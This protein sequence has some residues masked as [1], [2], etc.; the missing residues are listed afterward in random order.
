MTSRA[1]LLA[2][3]VLAST[4]AGASG[5]SPDAGSM[6]ANT[7]GNMAALGAKPAEG[8]PL[9]YYP[10]YRWTD[11]FSIQVDS[12]AIQGNSLVSHDKLQTAVQSYIGQRLTVQ[13]LPSVSA[14]VTKAY[15][16]AGYRVKAYIP[17]QTFTRGRLIVQVIEME[18]LR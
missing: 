12:I 17:E 15:K 14:A 1:I 10:K 2:L 5:F 3:A 18:K 11:D 7:E 4:Q 9:E 13:R 8:F 16:D 6:L